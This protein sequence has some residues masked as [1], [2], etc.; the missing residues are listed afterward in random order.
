M[1]HTSKYDENTEIRIYQGLW[2]NLLLAMG[3]LIFAVCGVFII[4][5]DGVSFITKLLGGWLSVIFCGGC[6]L[7]LLI[8]T[9]YNRLRNIPLI[10]ICEDRFE[11]YEQFKGVY[12]IIKFADVNGFRL[13]K[14]NSTKFIAIDY[15]NA[16]MMQKFD[17][18]SGFMQ[19]LMSLNF[20]VTGAVHNIYAD[21]LTMKGKDICEILNERL[22]RYKM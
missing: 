5:D 22:E 19:K 6:G 16:P 4:R 10:I 12:R 7:F 9:L 1:K 17:E 14:C 15:K 3:C 21:N 8:L 13:V 11:L 2:K 18:S 20:Q